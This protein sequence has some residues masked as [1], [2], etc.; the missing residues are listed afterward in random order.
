[1]YLSRLSLSNVRHFE[2]RSFQFKP[3][4]NLIVGEN[5]AGKTSILRGL[6]AVLGHSQQ[7]WSRHRF[8][9][10]DIRINAQHAEITA[11][12]Q[13]SHGEEFKAHFYK[14][15]FARP[16]RKGV[17]RNPP[18]VL[19]FGANE[20][21]CG[22]LKTKRRKSVGDGDAAEQRSREEWLYNAEMDLSVFQMATSH[23]RFGESRTVRAFLKQIL[24]SFDPEMGG[25]YWR[26]EPYDCK[27]VIPPDKERKQSIPGEIAEMARSA[28]MRFFMKDLY[29]FPLRAYP[30]PEQDKVV[31]VPGQNVSAAS[32]SYLPDPHEIWELMDIPKDI[33]LALQSVSLEVKL[34]PRIIIRRKN[35]PM[36]LSQ[37]SDGEQRLFSLFV[38]IARQLS[39]K[40]PSAEIGKGE[41]IVLIDE[42]DVHLHPKWQRKIVPAL[43]DLFPNCQFIATTHSP[44][45]I[46]ATSRN[47]IKSIDAEVRNWNPDAG[48]SLE[49]I[50]EEIQGVTL[51]QRSA[52]A[53]RL[54]KAAERY[55]SLLAGTQQSGAAREQAELLEAERDYRQASEP[56]TMDPATHALLKVQLMEGRGQ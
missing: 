6:M 4:F 44:F 26:F 31:L 35:G 19:S 16:K 28:A 51:P 11:D 1:M 14:S 22:A 25:F 33:W 30:W 49:D 54:S 3:G 13:L 27:L 7:W 10:D 8:D 40:N 5:G 48:N 32:E 55:F 2:D 50:A 17:G 36:R 46:Q 12:V 15:L 56:F 9:D 52:R 53:E 43:E 29:G 39:L 34:T 41:A 47:N 20:S 42:I 38:E 37:L 24:R 45:V 18:L 21:T 23:R